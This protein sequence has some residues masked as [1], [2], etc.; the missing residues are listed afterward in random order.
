MVGAL[1]LP[2]TIVGIVDASTTHNQSSTTATGIPYFRL[3]K[4][5]VPYLLALRLAWM[6]ITLL[7]EL[8]TLR[9]VHEDVGIYQHSN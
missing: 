6:I 3:L 2:E 9:L 4:Y 5:T 7:P 1:V 8:A